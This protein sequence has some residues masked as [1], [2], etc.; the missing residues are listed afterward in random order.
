MVA[1]RCDEIV[2]AV[3]GRLISGDLNTIIQNVCTDSRKI[4]QHSL[5]V[6]IVG[7]NFDGHDFVDASVE[8]G[9]NATLIE[10]GKIEQAS[11]AIENNAVVIEVDDTIRA[12]GAIAKYYR[13]KFDILVTGITGSVGKTTTKEMISCVMEQQYQ[14]LKTAGNFNNEIGLP[15]TLFRLEP[16]HEAAVIEMGMSN[17]GEIDRL[18]RIATPQMAVITNVG[19]SHIESLGSRENIL[20]AK[21]EILNGMD[22]DGVAIINID[23]NLLAGAVPFL[24]KKVVTFGFDESADIMATNA[25]IFDNREVRFDLK[26]LG[27]SYEII[28]PTLGLHNVYNALAAVAVG[29][30]ANISIDKIIAGIA[31]YKMQGF[32]LNVVEHNGVTVI[33]DF[34]NASPQSMKSSLDVL[35][36]YDTNGKQI[37]LLGDMYELGEWTVKSH[38]D[39]GRWAAETNV[40]YLI[41]VGK[42]AD[43]IAEGALKA[44]LE[45][46]KIM[47]VETNDEA[48]NCLKA[49]MKLHDVVL[50]KASRAGKLEEVYERVF[51]N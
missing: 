38:Q 27:Q 11:K 41:C 14:V 50:I 24:N 49:V 17:L 7:A 26:Y 47:C 31:N 32:R 46:Q 6:P 1:L 35:R 43:Y 28:V 34:Y 12:L 25:R 29:I 10:K 22:D 9:A 4:E 40:D 45:A 19:A 42:Y 36:D 5:F 18:T 13:N 48:A 30:E 3:S 8:A 44:G 20:R 16:K 23:D 39:V 21:L 15:I 33:K 37:A 2:K 51:G